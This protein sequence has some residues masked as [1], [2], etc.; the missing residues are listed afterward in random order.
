MVN[1]N[2]TPTHSVQYLPDEM[3]A[4][5]L[6]NGGTYHV[7]NDRVFIGASLMEALCHETEITG[8]EASMVKSCV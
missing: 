1:F 2:I 8:E 6:V 4:V 5:V 3:G 7:H